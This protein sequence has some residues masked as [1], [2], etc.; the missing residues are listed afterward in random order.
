V[1]Y[2]SGGASIEVDPTVDERGD[3]AQAL[4]TIKLWN[5]RRKS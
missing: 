5:P 2:A 4:G 3:Q 1:I